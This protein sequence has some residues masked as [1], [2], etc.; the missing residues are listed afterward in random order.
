MEAS[1]GNA[2][3]PAP[4]YATTIPGCDGPF[5]RPSVFGLFLTISFCLLTQPQGTLFFPDLRKS[6]G[7][8]VAL[9]RLRPPYSLAEAAVVI[10]YLIRSP[11]YAWREGH[12]PK[13]QVISTNKRYQTRLL[14]NLRPFT[15][16][17]RMTAVA[18]LS[19]R[20]K[21]QATLLAT[22]RAQTPSQEVEL[23]T[24]P[25]HTTRPG[26][27]TAADTDPTS[28]TLPRRRITNLEDGITLGASEASRDETILAT[29]DPDVLPHGHGLVDVVTFLSILDILAKLA[30]SIL[31]W[32]IRLTAWPLVVGWMALHAILIIFH[33]GGEDGINTLES[34]PLI[35]ELRMIEAELEGPTTVTGFFEWITV[36]NMSCGIYLTYLLNK[37]YKP[38]KLISSYLGEHWFPFFV[39]ILLLIVEVLLML[40]A[41]TPYI[42]WGGELA[43]TIAV[44]IALVLCLGSWAIVWAASDWQAQADAWCTER[45][46]GVGCGLFSIYLSFFLSAFICEEETVFMTFL[47]ATAFSVLLLTYN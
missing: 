36:I 27:A 19:V 13:L 17:I 45:L 15:S 47:M 21:K 18:L 35:R 9:I 20:S 10:I 11:W 25:P 1:G 39:M 32:P 44:V 2:T 3:L 31:S 12:R 16:K 26:Q 23:T 5:S 28:G 43:K 29:V 38:E 33:S 24:I 37:N 4:G 8:G 42:D 22:L 41:T 30:F 46:F 7:L 34:A 40:F 6:R 14:L